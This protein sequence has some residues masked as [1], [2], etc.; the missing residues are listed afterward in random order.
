[1]FVLVNVTNAM[2]SKATDTNS[3]QQQMVNQ[4]NTTI[5]QNQINEQTQTNN[6]GENTQIRIQKSEQVLNNEPITEEVQNQSNG[7]KQNGSEQGNKVQNKVQEMEQIQNNSTENGQQRR[8]QVANAVHEML[9]VAERNGGIGDQ[10]RN[11]AQAQ[12]ENQDKLE[13]GLEK[14]QKRN[15]ILKFILGPDYKEINNIEE[16]LKQNTEQIEQIIQA[17]NQIQNQN[18]EQ[19]LSEQIQLLEGANAEIKDKIQSYPKGF[20]LFGWV[21]RLMNK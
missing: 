12:N 17:K 11:V 14:I 13:K 6:Q 3:A 15:G 18:D 19:I 2:G 20:S 10:I 9:Q 5:N 7:Q 1:M 8:S 16:I 21:S 4:S